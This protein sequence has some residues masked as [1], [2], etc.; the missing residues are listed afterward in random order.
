MV[1]WTI[2]LA[3]LVGCAFCGRGPLEGQC[4][5]TTDCNSNG[6]LDACDLAIGTSDD[7]DGNGVPD[8]CD[9][10]AL[11]SVDCNLNGVPDSCE[12]VA[13]LSLNSVTGL[14]GG[15][16]RAVS[17]TDD[18][19][20]V[21]VP[22]DGTLGVN[23]GAAIVFHRVGT[24]WVVS[25]TLLAVDGSAGDLFGTSVSIDGDRI[26]IGAPGDSVGPIAGS[27]AV[28]VYERV[29]G[30]WTFDS[31]LSNPNPAVGDQFGAAVSVSG[32]RVLIGA[33]QTLDPLATGRAHLYAYTGLLYVEEATLHPI[34]L[35]IGDQF[36]VSV[37]L[38]GDTAYV[39]A[40]S[41]ISLAQIDAGAV[42]A[43]VRV[44]GSWLESARLS[45]PL[46][47]TGDEFGAS[48]KG[49]GP[50][51]VVG[52]PA[53][54]GDE[55]RASLFLRVGSNWIFDS[56]LTS[57][58]AGPDLFG[59][60]VSVLENTLIIGEEKGG[61]DDGLA[62]LYD[63]NGIDWILR[64]S[65]DLAGGGDRFGSGVDLAPLHALI[66]VRG[67]TDAFVVWAATIPDCNE[68]GIEDLCE[69]V[70]GAEADCDLNGI[71]DACDVAA[72]AVADCNMNGIPDNCEIVSGDESDCNLNGAIDSCDIAHGSVTDCNLNGVPDDCETDCD[73]NGVPDDCELLAG[74]ADCNDNGL[75]DICDIG[76]GLEDDC[77]A[78][79]IPDS[80][81]FAILTSLDCNSNG[82]P[83]ECDIAA[84][85][86]S[87]C[88]GNL[89]LDSCD[90]A[91][92][93]SQDCNFTG[94]LDECEIASGISQDC[95]LNSTPDECDIAFGGAFDCNSNGVPDACEIAEGIIVDS[96]PP[97]I[98]GTYPDLTVSN[99]TGVCGAILSWAP[100]LFDDDCQ[101]VTTTVSHQPGASFPVGETT[102]AFTAVDSQGNLTVESFRVTVIDDEAPVPVGV[103]ADVF[104]ENDPGS[105]GAVFSWPEPSATDNC[106]VAG[107]SSSHTPGSVFLPGATVVTTSA[108]DIH[109]NAAMAIFTVT[110]SDVLPP[111]LS[112]VPGDVLGDNDPGSC[113]AAITWTEPTASDD[114]GIL[115]LSSDVPPGS[116]FPIGS[117]TV[118]YTA[119]DSSG[120]TTSSSFMVTV[121]DV[122][123]PMLV[124]TPPDLD[125]PNDPGLCVAAASWT[126]PTV[127]DNCLGIT[128]VASH[129]PGT[130][131]PLGTTT[132]TY[133]A[134]DPGGNT[135]EITFTVTV[136]DVESPTLV[137]IPGNLVVA[138][139]PGICGATITWS[140]PIAGDNCPGMTMTSDH[141]PGEFFPIGVTAVSYI[142]T[143]AVEN[144][145]IANFTI[146]VTDDEGPEVVIPSDL[147]VEAAPGLCSAFIDWAAPTAVDNCL[148]ASLTASHTPPLSLPVGE[149][150]VTV[151]AID[152]SGNSTTEVFAVT[153]LDTEGPTIVPGPDIVV[154]IDP[155]TCFAVVLVPAPQVSDNCG[156][157]ALTND[158]TGTSNASG[159]YPYG[160]TL[161]NWT[162]VDPTGAIAT[163]T[164]IITVEAEAIDCNGNGVLDV[165]DIASGASLD[166]NDNQVPDEC[167][168]TFRRG[169]ANAD[170]QIDIADGVFLLNYLFLNGPSGDCQDSLDVNDD[171]QVQLSDAIWVITYQFANGPEPLSPFLQCGDD[172]TP[173]SLGC[174]TGTC[175]L[176]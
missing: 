54:N 137:G 121:V 161:V 34:S 175:P 64:E 156:I 131:F 152:T 4:E 62:H 43:F 40:P 106:G 19:A 25:N 28:Y 92:G 36:G 95:D 129:A 29:V 138:N 96:T 11:A 39:G 38:E 125:L 42:Y 44:T 56:A 165:C 90:M 77:N 112:G 89:I 123:A 100:P 52:S 111:V 14:G 31:K 132:V 116:L 60:S 67:N 15:S 144:V 33:P 167:E 99:A 122:Q 118:T 81:D 37:D 45:S 171:G 109:G 59:V 151:T 164:Q 150:T 20:V 49:S 30:N 63:F 7:C 10:A 117:T 76:I 136:S 3:W 6:V 53:W 139:D 18:T 12:P 93:T 158:H 85:L 162:A 1:R 26:V 126:P 91:L 24:T 135:A 133:S 146:T 35:V 75:I 173:D 119:T 27:G 13:P 57:P 127:D 160:S 94:T 21:G 102:V 80:C 110:V 8:E 114:C 73:G 50:W 65:L 74:A 104:I 142:A 120:L 72:G 108:V 172:L 143:D 79:G 98:T 69:I 16:G 128:P 88:N 47:Q 170:G 5:P 48:L 113:G 145:S 169:D 51:L 174:D 101:L 141:S 166:E 155:A 82:I 9:I 134:T 22:G 23:A 149:T 70:L 61:G 68:N 115:D 157:A 148:V 86:D 124:G 66:G 105:C 103:P 154:P 17:I 168:Q 163:A 41:A 84:G 83:D 78:N 176:P 55:G 107:V 140:P 159:V 153:V 32:T 130:N 147:V 71:P 97:T 2:V 46:A 58:V 87:D